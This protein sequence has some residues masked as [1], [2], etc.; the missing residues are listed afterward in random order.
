[1]LEIFAIAFLA[2]SNSKIAQ[3]K[4]RSPVAFALLT[5]GLWVG[6][7][8]IGAIVG[9]FVGEGLIP[10]VFA[11][12]FAGIGGLISYLI[13]KN[14]STGTYISAAEKKIIETFKASRPLTEP[15]TII[16]TNEQN[17]NSKYCY[18]YNNNEMIQGVEPGESVTIT[19]NQS[20]NALSISFEPIG[21][22]FSP[23]LVQISE[24]ETKNVRYMHGVF[25]LNK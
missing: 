2:S 12:L 14:I 24:G 17:A 22:A 15:G 11:L 6:F 10:Y 7:E 1:M 8:F 18:L 13:V 21:G 4:R 20:A 9:A 19:A 16:F 23:F 25:I 5:V 3:G